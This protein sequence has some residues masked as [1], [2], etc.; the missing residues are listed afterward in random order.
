MKSI[1]RIILEE[2]EKEL[3]NL[4]GELTQHESAFSTAS[5]FSISRCLELFEAYK[6]DLEAK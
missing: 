1:H 6:E 5:K 2:L 3:N 4:D